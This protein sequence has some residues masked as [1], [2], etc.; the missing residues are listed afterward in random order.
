MAAD[1][2]DGGDVDVVRHR[3]APLLVVLSLLAVPLAP[4]AGDAERASMAATVAALEAMGNRSTHEKQW[5]AARWIAARFAEL[6]L[7]VTLPTYQYQGRSWPNVVA[8]LEGGER[9]SEVI[10]PIAHL[11]STAADD[12]PVAPGAD[13]NASGVAVLLEIA[14]Q[15]RGRTPAR[16]VEF[17]VFSN[18][19]ED[20]AGSRAFA[21]AARNSGTRIAAVVN[22]DVLGY[23][24]PSGAADW[25]AVAGIRSLRARLRA[26][27]TVTANL[28]RSLA[29]PRRTIQVAGRPA[30]AALVAAVG[31]QMEGDPRLGV[32]KVVKEDCG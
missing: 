21:R 24:G 16:T 12:P 5:E 2:R 30:S 28:A 23:P 18:E 14:R 4:R 17:V 29:V 10:L 6:G 19:E 26:L 22:F 15:L 1:T 27:G 25:R 3:A 31:G 9:R 7:A 13:D 32:L 20:A 8:T 11:D